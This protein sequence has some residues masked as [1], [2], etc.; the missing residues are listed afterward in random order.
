[1][2]FV[3]FTLNDFV[4]E[5]GGTIRIVGILNELANAN[6]EVILISNIANNKKSIF[7][8]KIQHIEIDYTFSKRNKR[9]FQFILSLFPISFVNMIYGKLLNRLE[10]IFSDISNERNVY[11]FEYLDNSIGYWLKENKIVQ[12]NYNDLHGVAPLEFS[13]K[14]DQADTIMEKISYRLAYLISSIL[15]SK[16]LSSS[17]GLIFASKEM[18]KY[19]LSKYKSLKKKNNI[20]LPYLL[21]SDICDKYEIDKNLQKELKSKYP[22]LEDHK[23]IMFAGAFKKTGGVPDLVTA[24][25]K[26]EKSFPKTC[27][28]LIGDGETMNECLEIV[29]SKDLAEKVKFIGRTPYHELPTYQSLADIIVCPD[30]MNAYSELIVH[31]KY[32]DALISDK[33]VICGSFKSVQE[34]NKN[35]SFSVSY[36]PSNV[37]DLT[38]ALKEVLNDYDLYLDRYKDNRKKVCEKYTYENYLPKLYKINNK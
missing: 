7:S 9:L 29:R 8:K 18:K 15:D 35:D 24:F 4:K 31:V 3:F 32:F 6:N 2:K 21:N 12:N 17:E 30:K 25:K 14:V 22:I 13:F 19:Y 36:E 38:D 11:F 20:V 33:V 34:I 10:L 16:V 26:V 1:M 27:L 37:D 5:G 28:L 23:V